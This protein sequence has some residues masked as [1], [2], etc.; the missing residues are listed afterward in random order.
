L[1]PLGRRLIELLHKLLALLRRHAQ[2]EGAHT[3]GSSLRR[4]GGCR[5]LFLAPYLPLF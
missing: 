4:K 3:P 2:Y 1:L 5:L